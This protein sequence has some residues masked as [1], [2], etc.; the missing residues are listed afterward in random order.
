MTDDPH[1]DEVLH[2]L[3]GEFGDWMKQRASWSGFSEVLRDAGRARLVDIASDRRVADEATVSL[4]AQVSLIELR[5]IADLFEERARTRNRRRVRLGALALVALTLAGTGL[6]L[7]SLGGASNFVVTVGAF[8]VGALGALVAL[9][10]V[11]VTFRRDP[12]SKAFEELRGELAEIDR[13]LLVPQARSSYN[14][15]D[16][17]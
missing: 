9:A 5:K 16:V 7:A 10:S 3:A 12:F 1:P 13:T 6:L 11:A 2:L 4:D 15:P 8:V 17:A 14:P